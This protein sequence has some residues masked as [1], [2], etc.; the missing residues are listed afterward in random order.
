MKKKKKTLKKKSSKSFVIY[1]VI[2]TLTILAF[3]GFYLYKNLIQSPQIALLESASSAR[4][5]RLTIRSGDIVSQSTGKSVKLRGNNYFKVEPVPNTKS[6]T[7]SDFRDVSYKNPTIVAERLQHLNQMQRDG[8]NAIRIFIDH[9]YIMKANSDGSYVLDPAYLDNLS[10]FIKLA[11]QKGLYVLATFRRMPV[12]G[13]YRQ[14]IT[15]PNF[16]NADN[17]STETLAPFTAEYLSPTLLEGKKR[18]VVDVI[19]GLIERQTPLAA[20]FGWSIDNEPYLSTNYNPLA[21]NKVGTAKF[22]DP[23]KTYNLKGL[24]NNLA[25]Q[26]EILNDSMQYVANE[27][28]TAIKNVAGQDTLVGIS[29]GNPT[30]TAENTPRRKNTLLPTLATFSDS[31]LDYIDVHI[32]PGYFPLDQE[33]NSYE[34]NKNTKV[35]LLG[36][37]GVRPNVE[38][39][40]YSLEKAANEL[41]NLQVQTCSKYNFKGW[42]TY[43]YANPYKDSS[44]DDGF[45]YYHAIEGNGQINNAL[46]P[47]NRP[48]PCQSSS[49]KAEVV[50]GRAPSNIIV[51]ETIVCGKNLVSQ[52]C[53]PTT[54]SYR[55]T[56][57]L[58]DNSSIKNAIFITWNSVNGTDD[59]QKYYGTKQNDL[60]QVKVD[61][62]KHAGRGGDMISNIWTVDSSGKQNWCSKVQVPRCQ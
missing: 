36:E 35:L 60:W 48:D 19:S 8:Y 34:F 16:F 14:T 40:A 47:I 11:D 37:F 51:P 24:G 53:L 58:A 3:L 10:N 31:K 54:G 61:Q 49:A 56:L 26:K 59:M 45:K 21:L 39:V 1:G 43:D 25:L 20:V 6:F 50:E 4:L 42:F 22:V 33:I 38:G 27:L 41:I 62:D 5:D 44:Y 18:Y 2:L 15:D 55:Y 28:S 17:K 57:K 32:Y 9:G 12:R 7:I 30:F 46:A 13:S 52:T 23:T 29:L